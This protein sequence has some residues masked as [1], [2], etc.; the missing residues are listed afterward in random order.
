[1]TIAKIETRMYYK[2]DDT[3]KMKSKT[4]KCKDANNSLNV[5]HSSTMP[6]IV[7]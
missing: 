1:M 3:K 7:L 2:N 4:N 6:K 5:G